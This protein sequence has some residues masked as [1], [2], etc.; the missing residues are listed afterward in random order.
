MGPETITALVKFGRAFGFWAM[1]ALI[2]GILVFRAIDRGFSV[3]VT[4]GEPPKTTEA[5]LPSTTRE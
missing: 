4:V 2:V 5:R 3:H 1:V